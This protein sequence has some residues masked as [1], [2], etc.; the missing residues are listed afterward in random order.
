MVVNKLATVGG[1]EPMPSS[2]PV[3]S[4]DDK[5]RLPDDLDLR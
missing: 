1:V 2:S 4:P 5:L 3:G